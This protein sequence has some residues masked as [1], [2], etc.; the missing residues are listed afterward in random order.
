MA[1]ISGYEKLSDEE[2][3]AKYHDGDNGAADFLM[4]KY[5]N[6][7]RMKARAYFLAGADND[8]LIQEGMIGLYKAVRDYN[9]HRDTIFMTF[10]SLCVARQIRSAMTAHNRKK[11]SP[12]NSYISLDTPVTDEMGESA[13]LSDVITSAD[14]KS[15]EDLIIDQEQNSGLMNAIF[16]NLSKMETLVLELYVEG[17]SY[18][19]I[20]QQMGKTEKAV[21]NAIQRI[22]SKINTLRK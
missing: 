14:E 3:V 1:P 9:P 2:L 8:D 22:R 10:A 20:A 6:F 21:D 4:E 11:N 13:K 19:E 16:E 5:K 18:S 12:L 17:L 15:P 7:V